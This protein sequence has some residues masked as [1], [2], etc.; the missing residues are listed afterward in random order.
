MISSVETR[1]ASART[2][3]INRCRSASGA[4]CLNVRRKDVVAAGEKSRGAREREQVL[5]RARRCA[6]K[7]HILH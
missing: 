6:V 2:V 4:I 5:G 1:S 3:R 7:N